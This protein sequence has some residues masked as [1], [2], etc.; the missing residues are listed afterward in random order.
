MTALALQARYAIVSR[1]GWWQETSGDWGSPYSAK[2][3][4]SPVDALQ[5]IDGL[6]FDG[7]AHIA[8]VVVENRP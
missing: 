8:T 6:V 1:Y 7:V 3:Y 5:E 2:L 4:D